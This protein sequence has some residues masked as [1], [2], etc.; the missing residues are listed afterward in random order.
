MK[1][2]VYDRRSFRWV[3]RSIRVKGDSREK[4]LA[5]GK[6][7]RAKTARKVTSSCHHRVPREDMNNFVAKRPVGRSLTRELPEGQRKKVPPPAPKGSNPSLS[8]FWGRW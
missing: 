4:S 6:K 8:S 1:K 5:R 2:M 7:R 3:K